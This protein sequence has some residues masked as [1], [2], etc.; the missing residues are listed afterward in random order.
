[1]LK[2]TK[3][4]F[5]WD[6]FYT[7]CWL[8]LKTWGYFVLLQQICRLYFIGI[9]HHHIANT[10]HATDILLTMA[11]GLRFDLV[12]ATSATLI[13]LIGFTLPSLLAKKANLTSFTQ[14]TLKY[15]R[16]FAGIFTMLTV[17]LYLGA[18]E[19]YREYKDIFNQFLFGWFYD[20]KAAILQTILTQH[21]VLGNSILLL[22]VLCLYIKLSGYGFKPHTPTLITK[23]HKTLAIIALVLF[24]LIG[25]RGSIGRRPIQLKDAGITTDTFLNKAIVS[26]Y[27]ALK[28]AIDDYIEAKQEAQH[29]TNLSTQNIQAMAQQFFHTTACYNSLAAYMKKSATGAALN[30]P[31][32]H[33]FIIIGESLDAWHMQDEYKKFNLTPNLHRLINHGAI[34]FKYFLPGAHGTMET[35]NTI[36]TG[37]P[38]ANMHIN[39]QKSAYVAY[40]TAIAQ[41]FKQLGFTAQFFY[42]GYLSWQRLGDFAQAQGFDH[43]YGGAHMQQGKQTN[44]WGVDDKTLFEFVS[45]NIQQAKQP[46][47]NVIMTTS[48]HPPFSIDLTMEK[49][50]RH[51]VAQHTD[52][53]IH[54]LGHIWYTDKIIGAFVDQIA[55]M[56]S[57][58]L[59]A[60]TG[61]H[62]GRRHIM[63]DPSLFDT[64]A[65]PLIIYSKNKLPSFNGSRVAGSHLDLAPTII[66]MIAPPGFTYYTIGESLL[67]KRAF[68]LGIGK[69]RIITTDFI[70][71]TDSNKIMLFNHHQISQSSLTKLI[72]RYNQMMGIARYIIKK[73]VLLNEKNTQTH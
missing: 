42:G 12:W 34:H 40:P 6:N 47:F 30:N 7:Q 50:P 13:T 46:T 9:L 21:H 33:I 10:T 16:C 72:T 4:R 41:Q 2:I 60:I 36:I 14:R 66:E 45:A 5:T 35:L 54:E 25:L 55:A 70:A 23:S 61:D 49:F 52:K 27:S 59:F 22:I 37:I 26:P 65:V 53:Y 20:D 58:A 71:A 24:Y 38:D 1:M 8:D 28:Y 29:N 11:N 44:E 56:D 17:L 64:S 3:L 67:K 32:K 69:N 19:Y 63:L 68:N 39:Y 18:I 62:Y 48:N 73:G 31:P 15:R 43:V 51:L 57:S